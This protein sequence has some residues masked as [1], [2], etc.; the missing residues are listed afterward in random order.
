MPVPAV[1]PKN[2]ER[3]TII[4][5]FVTAT[6]VEIVEE[7]S[8]EDR[9]DTILNH[10]KNFTQKAKQNEQEATRTDYKTHSDFQATRR[11][12]Y[13]RE[14]SVA[15]EKPHRPR[16]SDETLTRLREK[17]KEEKPSVP[18][19]RL[20]F[21]DNLGIVLDAAERYYKTLQCE[22]RQTQPAE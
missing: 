7:L 21:D 8:F 17:V 4:C 22:L 20:D 11:S 18:A 5:H 16:I 2:W 14:F 13:R 9:L 1:S 3:T 15:R 12:P 19:E 10:G 6:S